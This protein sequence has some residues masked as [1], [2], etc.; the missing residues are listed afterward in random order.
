MNTS[1]FSDQKIDFTKEPMFFGTGKNLQR[2]DV[3]KY[4]FFDTMYEKQSGFFWRPQEINLTKDKA[5]YNKLSPSEKHIFH[6]NLK[7]QILLD[8][9]QGR[10]PVATFAQLTT[11][12]EAESC[13]TKLGDFEVL[14][15]KSY[16][17]IIRNIFN[18]PSEIFDSIMDDEFIMRRAKTMTDMY[19]DL[20]Y[21]TNEYIMLSL[22]GA[23]IS[24]EFMYNL[25]KSV[26]LALI[27][28][29][30]LEGIRFYNSF[31][32]SFAFAENQAMEGNAKEVKLIARDENI[33][34]AISQFIINTL[35]KNPDEG[36]QEVIADCEEEVYA[37][38]KQASEE[39]QEWADYLFKDGSIIGLNATLLK[40]YNKH[41]INKRLSAIGYKHIY[42]HSENPLSW[43]DNWLNSSNVEVAPQE[44]ELTS[45]VVGGLDASTTDDD[46]NIF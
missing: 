35:R 18:D 40:S 19:N 37:M 23:P 38:Y 44:T 33:H 25:K 26:Y 3:M 11:L 6:T 7:F 8:S 43:M 24:D 22:Q 13:L 16:S 28:W 12:P 45:Y 32:C 2:Y 5:D 9:L 41:L 10:G 36:F 17:H 34:L 1:L 4:K 39:E 20:Y 21:K 29:N 30:I 46:W 31:A 42:E 27:N 14:H 15:S